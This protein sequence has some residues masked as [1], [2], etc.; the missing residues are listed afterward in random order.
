M[1]SARPPPAGDAGEVEVGEAQNIS[2]V[3]KGSEFNPSRHA[4][5]ACV[6]PADLIFGMS[7]PYPRG[8]I[9]PDAAPQLIFDAST[10]RFGIQGLDPQAYILSP[11]DVVSNLNERI[12]ARDAPAETVIDGT[13]GK[14]IQE[15]L[16]V[17]RACVVQGYVQIAP[18]RPTDL[19]FRVIEPAIF[20][21]PG[22][23]ECAFSQ[24][25]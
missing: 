9:S 2:R 19:F 12:C 23:C 18:R 15:K 25:E 24:F 7:G 4:T 8:T 6:R 14:V 5:R 22:V 3:G 1:F 20:Q 21:S 11:Y 13:N 16:E 17:S 10:V